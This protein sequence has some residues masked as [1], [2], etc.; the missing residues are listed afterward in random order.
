MKLLSYITGKNGLII[1]GFVVLCVFIY[2]KYKSMRYFK[3]IEK[4]QKE[5]ERKK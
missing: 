1:V 5:K 3:Y 2:N 4:R